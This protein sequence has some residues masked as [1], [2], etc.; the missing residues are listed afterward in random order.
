MTPIPFGIYS[1]SLDSNRELEDNSPVLPITLR[2][3][4]NT[5]KVKEKAQSNNAFIIVVG[6]ETL[7]TYHF[8]P[9]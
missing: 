7:Q 4:Q 9:H 2:R 3:K 5:Q 1:V 6:K 8:S